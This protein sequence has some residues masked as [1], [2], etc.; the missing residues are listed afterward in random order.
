MEYYLVYV[1]PFGFDKER[2]NLVKAY[3]LKEAEEKVKELI[4][5][6]GDNPDK[7][8]IQAQETIE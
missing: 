8:F 6:I 3:S 4:K 2:Y 1:R 5:S 7:H